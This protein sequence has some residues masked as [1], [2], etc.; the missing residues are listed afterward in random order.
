MTA[1]RLIHGERF[2]TALNHA[3]TLKHDPRLIP[4]WRF[5]S[6]DKIIDRNWL[7]PAGAPIKWGEHSVG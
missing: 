4:S 2:R 5:L 7:I 1:A 3:R 6:L